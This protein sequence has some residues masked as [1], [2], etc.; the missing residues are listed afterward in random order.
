MILSSNENDLRSRLVLFGRARP[1]LGNCAEYHMIQVKQKEQ[2]D[3]EAQGVDETF[4]D[5]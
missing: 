5:A 1:G 4:I 3:D 2:G